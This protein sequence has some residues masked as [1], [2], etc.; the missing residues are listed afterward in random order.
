MIDDLTRSILEQRDNIENQRNREIK[1]N[2]K[3]YTTEDLLLFIDKLRRENKQLKEKIE[4]QTKICLADHKYASSKEDEV[5]VLTHQRDLYKEVI[6]EARDRITI[7]LGRY[8]NEKDY[9]ID[10]VALDEL[11]QILD[12][13]KGE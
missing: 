8:I 12:K 7:K 10:D 1:S 11:L 9:I 2:E 13:V 6:E 5:I 3:S 4:Q